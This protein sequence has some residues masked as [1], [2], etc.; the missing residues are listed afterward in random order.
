MRW[1]FHFSFFTAISPPS[2]APARLLILISS[3][4]FAECT[5]RWREKCLL[6]N[7]SIKVC[8][9]SEFSFSFLIRLFADN[10]LLLHALHAV[11]R[12]FLLLLLLYEKWA[13]KSLFF[14]FSSLPRPPR[15]LWP[16]LHT[17]HIFPP[18]IH[19]T[20]LI[21]NSENLPSRWFLLK[22][23]SGTQ[24]SSNLQVFSRNNN[25]T[26]EKFQNVH[27][28]CVKSENMSASDFN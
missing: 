19:T 18:L 26:E 2:P 4:T 16:V 9:F 23:F 5:E 1:I 17:T 22:N 25:Q 12:V 6:V 24:P 21:S 7:T 28:R 14:H 8:S 27:E 3:K 11:F 13:K 15:T 10:T 20:K